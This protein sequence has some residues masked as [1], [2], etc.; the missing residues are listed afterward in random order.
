VLPAARLLLQPEDWTALDAVF[1]HAPA[2]P[3]DAHLEF[4]QLLARI[5]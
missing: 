2:G 4:Q 3:S 5:G 1:A